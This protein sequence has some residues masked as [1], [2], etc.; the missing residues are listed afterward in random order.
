MATET[1]VIPGGTL[2]TIKYPPEVDFVATHGQGALL[3]ASDGRE[4]VDFVLGSGPMV[5]GHAHPKVVA[6]IQAQAP[7]G[8]Q[9]FVINDQAIRL[10]NR[11]AEVVPCA[12]AVKFLGDGSE[13]TFYGMRLARAFTGKSMVLK[14]EGAFHGH[15]DY[16]MHGVTPK[17]RGNYPQAQPDSAGIPDSVGK[18]VLVAPYNDLDAATEITLAHADRLAAIIVEPVQRA[19]LPL[20]GFLAGLRALADRIGALLIFDEVVTGFRLSLGGAQQKFGVTPD[21]CALGKIVGGGLPLAAIVGRRD[22]IEL[23][24]PNRPDDGKSVYLNGTL[25]GNPLASAAGLATI[26]VLVEENGPAKLEAKGTRYREALVE[27]AERLSIPFQ[28]IGPSAFPEPIFGSAP[29]TD[30]ASHEASNRKAARQFGLELMKRGIYVHLGS[31]F[32]ISLAHSDALLDRAAAKATEAMA[33]VR[34]AGLLS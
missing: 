18:T 7:R 25:N 29:V 27:A 5:L 32:Y 30:Y 8:T 6:A 33:A 14:F 10:A 2:G 34:D 23:T 1:L 19:L 9:F 16:A 3:W 12:E 24:V 17:Q 11:I 4:F 31:K 15:Q 22:L 20:P 13:A 21:L 26:D 28:M